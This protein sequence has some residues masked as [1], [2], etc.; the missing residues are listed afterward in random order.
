M[1]ILYIIYFCIN[2]DIV[3][4]SQTDDGSLELR[5]ETSGQKKSKSFPAPNGA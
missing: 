3:V 5:P 1:F 2:F 4:V